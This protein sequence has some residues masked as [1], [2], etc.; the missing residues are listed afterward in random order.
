MNPRDGMSGVAHSDFKSLVS[1]S[2][3][4][5]RVHSG[6]PDSLGHGPELRGVPHNAEPG[7]Y[8]HLP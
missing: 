2:V 8:I 1:H 4:N 6:K 5:I 7:N 3:L